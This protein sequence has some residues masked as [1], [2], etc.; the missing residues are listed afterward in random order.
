MFTEFKNTHK[1]KTGNACFS[2]K[3]NKKPFLYSAIL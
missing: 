1:L 2:E 3:I